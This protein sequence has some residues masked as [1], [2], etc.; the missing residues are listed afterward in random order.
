MLPPD[1]AAQ[2][3]EGVR[4]NQTLAV[5]WWATLLPL[6][7]EPCNATCYHAN[8]NFDECI[9]NALLVNNTLNTLRC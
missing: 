1:G 8:F 4:H 3:A 2:I 9:Y 6:L 7:S 5:L